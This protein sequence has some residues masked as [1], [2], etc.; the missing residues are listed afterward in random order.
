MVF[1]DFSL[2]RYNIFKAHPCCII[3]QCFTPLYCGTIFHW[4]Y[5]PCFIYPPISL[6]TF[7]LSLFHCLWTMLLYINVQF[8]W[9]WTYVFI[10][11][12]YVPKGWIVDYIVTP[13][14]TIWGTAR[15]FSNA[16]S[17]FD[18]LTSIWHYLHLLTNTYYCVSFYYSHPNGCEVVSHHRF[19]LFFPSD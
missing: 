12:E 4:L 11:P 19:V 5:R 6:W 3:Y 7:G 18:F 14:L 9:V 15:Q 8:L 2:T 16:A 1:C 13:C 10:S 17:P